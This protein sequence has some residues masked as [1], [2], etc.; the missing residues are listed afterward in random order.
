MG[1]NSL[2]IPQAVPM[3]PLAPAGQAGVW[4]A[5]TASQR[6]RTGDGSGAA[7][8]TRRAAA[9]NLEDIARELDRYVPKEIPSS[10]LQI[11]HDDAS[12]L[13][14]YRSVDQRSGEVLKQYPTEEMV[15]FISF[16]REREG[17]VVDDNI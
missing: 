6:A 2:K 7:T 9:V 17:L 4:E 12:G 14:I 1:D 3:P 5:R 13:F 11:E 16:Y 15:K 8:G 10:R